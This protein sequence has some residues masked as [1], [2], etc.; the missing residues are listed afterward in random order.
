MDYMMFVVEPHNIEAGM[1]NSCDMCPVAL[2]I[3][4]RYPE[5]KEVK[6]SMDY[7]EI[8]G[9]VYKDDEGNLEFFVS[10]FDADRDEACEEEW[11]DIQKYLHNWLEHG[12]LL[13]LR[14]EC[15]M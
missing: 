4:E 12:Y 5:T 11:E 7:V 1:Q 6:V 8:D 2:Q 13:T 15:E 3:K 10:T 9:D 14:P